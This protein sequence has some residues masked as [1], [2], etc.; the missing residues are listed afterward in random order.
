VGAV[1]PTGAQ[2]LQGVPGATG[3]AGAVGAVGP[4][5]AQGLQ[6]LQGAQGATGATGATGL[7]GPIGPTGST[8]ATGA[9]GARGATGATGAQGATGFVSMGVFG[10]PA[11]V[12]PAGSA[13]F[14]FFGGT[15]TVT[16]TAGQRLTASGQAPAGIQFA[17]AT[18]LFGYDICY[19][20]AGSSGALSTFN[21]FDYPYG[22]LSGQLLSWSSQGS[23]LLPAGTYD[24]GFCV[25]NAYDADIDYTANVT[26]WVFVSN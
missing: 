9:T 20:P 22:E 26:G 16:V 14:V 18:Q 2:G 8:G 11:D 12:V 19:R 13:D 15:A 24:V 5:G 4:T 6:G 21:G 3:A 10:G 23:V 7:Q 25:Y 1:G 17:S